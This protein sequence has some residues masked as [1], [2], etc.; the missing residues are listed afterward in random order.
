[1]IQQLIS[2][3]TESYTV[4]YRRGET[5]YYL[6]NGASVRHTFETDTSPMAADFD[7]QLAKQAILGAQS[8]P[9][10]SLFPKH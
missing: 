5:T 1:M 2:V 8:G 6:P 3:D 7:A 10:R 9:V 4:D